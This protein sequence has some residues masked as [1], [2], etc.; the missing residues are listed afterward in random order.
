MA[1]TDLYRPIKQFLE[2]RGYVVKGE[3]GPCDVVTVYVAFRIGPGHSGSWRVQEAG[4]ETAAAIRARTRDRLVARP[5]GTG[6]RVVA[7]A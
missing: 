5:G 3:I 7:S 4:R 2:A 1:E 6:S